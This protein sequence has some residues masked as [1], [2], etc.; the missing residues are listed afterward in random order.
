M[1]HMMAKAATI[2]GKETGIDRNPAD[3]V[4]VK[5]PD[6]QRERYL[7]AE[8]IQKLKATLDQKMYR[9]AGKGIDQTF[10]HLRLI[11]LAALTTGMRMAEIFS[12]RRSDLLFREELIAVRAKLKG[13]KFRYT[14]MPPEL[15]TEFKRYPVILG[16]DRI[17]PP[18][19]GAKRERQRVDK[20]FETILELA[21]IEHFRF[22]DLR[23]TFAS[24]YMM[25]GGDLYKLAKI[26]GH[27]NIKM[28][29]RY[30][31]LGKAHIAKT[32][33][34]AREMWRLMEGERREQLQRT[35]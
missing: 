13:G 11:V 17:F 33:S 22:H 18:E 3:A 16:E 9:K 10:F 23:H 7:S 6:D 20:S 27:S 4:E 32:G 1:H 29:E 25:N 15:A 34:T 35:R 14:P 24:W 12:L 5:R 26:L 30:A 2:W 28:R 8:E 21:G 31:K 19:P